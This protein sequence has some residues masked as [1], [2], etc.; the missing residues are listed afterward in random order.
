MNRTGDKG[1][2]LIE[3]VMF[4]V[5]GAIFIPASLVAFTSVMSNYSRP[6]YYVKAKYYADKRMA[7]VTNRT[8]DTIT[9]AVCVDETQ[10]GY[11]IKCTVVTI[12]PD[13]LSTTSPSAHYKHVTV[14]VSHS[15]LLS[16]YVISTIVTKR[17]KLS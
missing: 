17:P 13:D 6:D 10:G 12:N 8:Y 5:I 9:S 2:T 14:R 16:D 3:L 15:G 7:E 4:I 11:T 1:F